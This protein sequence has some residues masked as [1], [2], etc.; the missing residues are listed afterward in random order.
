MGDRLSGKVALISGAARGQGAAHAER[1]AEEGASVVLGD[2]RDELGEGVAKAISDR[3]L[4]AVYTHLDVT[5]TADWQAAVALAEERFGK[6][7]VLVNNAG[8]LGMASVTEETEEHWDKVIA[9]NQTGVF[10]G[11]KAAIPALR[12]AGGGS[13]INTSSIWGMVGA[14]DYISYQA[15]KGAVTL[16]S[17]SAALTY[18]GDGI[19]VNS[20]CPGWVLT[21]MNDEEGPEVAEFLAEATPLKRG[22]QPGEIS[23]GLVYLASDEASFVTGTELVIDGGFIAQ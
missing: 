10:L 16:M 14:E 12:R 19:R 15:S 18:A 13:I 7:D 23:H 6:L 11:M 9:V 1:F 22:A 17:K 21:P 4:A 5:R 3:G 8:I 20:V 2:V